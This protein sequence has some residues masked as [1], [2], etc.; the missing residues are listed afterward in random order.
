MQKVMM[1]NEIPRMIEIFF[2]GFTM[3]E[4]AIDDYSCNAESSFWSHLNAVLP[5][6]AVKF[7][8]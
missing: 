1:T 5:H 4:V 2:M 6:K 7:P 8:N 3:L